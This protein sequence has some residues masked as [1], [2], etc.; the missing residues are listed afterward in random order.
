MYSK[1]LSFA[2]QN[3]TCDDYTIA[4]KWDLSNETF[5]ALVM[6]PSQVF[7]ILHQLVLKNGLKSEFHNFFISFICQKIL[8]GSEVGSIECQMFVP[9]KDLS[10]GFCSYSSYCYWIH[11]QD[12]NSGP[13]DSSPWCATT[14]NWK[15]I[16]E[17]SKANNDLITRFLILWESDSKTGEDFVSSEEGGRWLWAQTHEHQIWRIFPGLENK[18]DFDEKWSDVIPQ[19]QLQQHFNTSNPNSTSA[20]VAALSVL[21]TLHY[22][23]FYQH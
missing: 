17:S 16:F 18:W 15:I 10:G 1:T 7:H 23:L 8:T 20:A 4:R 19:Q 11:W 6:C 3:V 2:V 22:W 13:S 14:F 12:S 21:E 9:T 5:L